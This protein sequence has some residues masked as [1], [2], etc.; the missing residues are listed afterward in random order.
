MSGDR[1]GRKSAN[2]RSGG[3]G[4]G[5]KDFIFPSLELGRSGRLEPHCSGGGVGGDK[6]G[7]FFPVFLALFFSLSSFPHFSCFFKF[8]S[9]LYGWLEIAIGSKVN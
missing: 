3:P 8:G 4:V 2:R 7:F 9:I 6:L 1:W 5:L